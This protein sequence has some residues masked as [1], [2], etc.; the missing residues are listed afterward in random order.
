MN[1]DGK[2][3][4]CKICGSPNVKPTFHALKCYDC[5]VLLYFPYP[6]VISTNLETD[7]ESREAYSLSW[8]K[9]SS[10]RNHVNFTNM[11]LFAIENPEEFYMQQMNILDFGGGGGQFAFIC[12]SFLPLSN[13]YI[14]DIDDFGLLQQYRCINNQILWNNFESDQTKF[15]FIFLND[16]FEH[17][18]DPLK[19]LEIL[20]SKLNIGGKIFIDTPKQFW[21]Y[22]FLK[23]SNKLLYQKLLTGTVSRSHLQIWSK[24]SFYY[25]VE[26]AG[27]KV[28]NFTE[29]SEFTMPAKH[30]L[31]NFGIKNKFIQIVG[32][33]FY[34][35]A[36]LLS[37]N[38][39]M[40]LLS[41]NNNEL[42]KSNQ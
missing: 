15:D 21:L 11:F 40:G 28:D 32:V 6:E 13:V 31:K 35:F 8:Y 34:R 3:I 37:K 12:K 30:Y 9:R 7:K 22:P 24:K 19:T 16:V 39:I 10:K 14:S 2:L 27:L 26:K 29:V 38:K 42:L 5:G 36:K 23:I 25:I 20:K 17:V 33:V 4:S 18:D 41:E 1:I